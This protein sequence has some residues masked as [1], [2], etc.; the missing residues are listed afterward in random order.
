MGSTIS[1]NF[2]VEV[3]KS[4]QMWTLRTQGQVSVAAV[5][6]RAVYRL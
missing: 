1:Q 3:D 6:V 5:S 4:S 2:A